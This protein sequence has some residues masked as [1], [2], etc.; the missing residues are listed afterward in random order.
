MGVKSLAGSSPVPPTKNHMR[1][2]KTLL[3]LIFA[4][5]IVGG[6]K[7]VGYT[8]IEENIKSFNT[9]VR[10]NTNGTIE[11]TEQI[12]YDFGPN[13]R[14][15]IFRNI[16]L[17][18]T[19]TDGK[20]FR[21]KIS[22]VRV[23]GD[24]FSTSYTNSHLEIKIGDPYKTITGVK[25]Y[26][27]EYVVSGA[28]T[29]FSDHDE[30]YWNMTG[31]DWNVPITQFNGKISV[32]ANVDFNIYKYACFSGI[33]GSTEQNCFI[34]YFKD[35]QGNFSSVNIQG[36]GLFSAYNGL[37]AVVGFPKNVVQVLEP[38][39]DNS[40]LWLAAVFFLFWV[41]FSVI[42]C[43]IIILRWWS[44]RKETKNKAQI[45]A[46]WFSPPTHES[47]VDFTPVETALILNKKVDHRSVTATIIHLAQKG[48]LK[49]NAQ[50]TTKIVFVRKKEWEGDSSLTDYEKLILGGI[51]TNG[52]FLEVT[53]KELKT[54]ASFHTK[55][56][57]AEKQLSSGAFKEGLFKE[58]PLSYLQTMTV[59]LTISTPFGIAF[60]PLLLWA[61]L[62]KNKSAR[63]TDLG[64]EKYS[65]A[66]SLKNFLVS[67]TEQLN[68]Q[69]HNQ[70][71]F[72]KLLPYATAM[73]VEKIWAKRFSDLT[74]VANDWYEGNTLNATSLVWSTSH[75]NS[76][77]KSSY[78]MSSTRSSS[79]FHSG[80]S[81][82]SSGGGGGGGGGGSW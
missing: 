72:E 24:K 18:K 37:T 78:V 46:A 10:I 38:K 66:Q 55:I 64:I 42:T 80:F 52:G 19:N 3:A 79:G 16:P 68:F 51:F 56:T 67:Q 45:V 8:S 54:R 34:S 73:G 33:A 6:T 26:V 23:D 81:G 40:G 28:L 2:L 41:L 1:T 44:D 71:F 43:I 7:A 74:F 4:I 61:W 5:T 14:H 70:M 27:I 60:L 15:G 12:I 31:N 48:Y 29:Y 30:L 77:V 69:A 13:E 50:N 36:K 75:I 82:G 58:N 59:L 20:R 47:K 76:S 21:L 22:D 65:K 17:I 9:D 49:I 53:D 39:T 25:A 11:I 63:R 62:V 57:K 32:P 35:P